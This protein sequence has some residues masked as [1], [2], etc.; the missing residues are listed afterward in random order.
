MGS[1]T[2]HFAVVP[3]DEATTL[4]DRAYAD[5]RQAPAYPEPVAA[6]PAQASVTSIGVAN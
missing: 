6:Y 4:T 3:A 5:S 2:S 1:G